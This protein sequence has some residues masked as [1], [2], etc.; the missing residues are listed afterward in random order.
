M[1]YRWFEEGCET[2]DPRLAKSLLKELGSLGIERHH[3]LCGTVSCYSVSNTTNFDS[4]SNSGGGGNS[5]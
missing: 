2:L 3:T 1:A 4:V 5:L